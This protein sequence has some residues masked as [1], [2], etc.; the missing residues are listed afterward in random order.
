MYINIST[1]LGTKRNADRSDRIFSCFQTREKTTRNLPRVSRGGALTVSVDLYSRFT[2]RQF[3]ID[4]PSDGR[5]FLPNGASRVPPSCRHDANA[6]GNRRK[7]HDIASKSI[8]RSV[9]IPTKISY[10]FDDVLIDKMFRIL[11]TLA[12]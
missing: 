4:R 2:C 3:E 12:I 6:N 7:Q 11:Y 5:G 9:N 10:A 8:R 1:P